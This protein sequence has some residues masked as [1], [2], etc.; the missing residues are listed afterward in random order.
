[1]HYFTIFFHNNNGDIMKNRSIWKENAKNETL[2]SLE[3]DIDCDV[4]IIGGGMAGISTAYFLKDSKKNIVLIDKERCA[5][6]ASSKNTGKL[7]FMQELI[8]HKI[9]KNYSEETACLYLESQKEAIS[10][11]K[12]IIKENNIDCNFFEQNSYVFINKDSDKKKIDSE[13][14]FYKKNNMECEVV[15]KIPVKLPII[16]GIKISGDSYSFNPYKFLV[17][18]KN[19]L[20]DKIK[21]YENTRAIEVK[22]VDDYYFVKTKNNK[23]IR[24]KYLV[25]AT[26]Y[27]FFIVP[28]FTPFKTSVEKSFIV[29]GKNEIKT[30][31]AISEGKPTFSFNYYKEDDGY[32]LYSRRSHSIT[33]NL[34]TRDDR[35]EI[36]GEYKKLFGKTPEYYFQNH[37]LM[38][39]DYIPFVGK[40]DDNN[41]FVLTGFNKW[42]NTNGV[43]GGKLISD[44]ILDRDNC[45]KELFDPKRSLSILKIKNLVIYNTMVMSRYILNKIV[46][47]QSYYDDRVKIEYRDGK[48]CGIYTD[49]KGEHVVS[50]ICPHMKCNLVFNYVDKTWDCPCHAS[51]FDIDGNVIYGPSVYDIKINKDC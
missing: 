35:E 6:G 9:V 5:E 39:Y 45:Y 36:V 29:S 23:K 11:I 22:K 8:Y 27:P 16:S 24:C 2:P 21:I 51:R 26:Q 41:M 47:S 38:S 12:N 30:F 10:L 40:I 37:D 17:S 3:N 15:N 20:K 18:V 32:L 13:I 14:D 34:D 49:D 25:I 1:M 4:L 42:G 43:I 48:K 19:I 44:L 46:S 31:Q 50:N 33:T 28:Y 7:T